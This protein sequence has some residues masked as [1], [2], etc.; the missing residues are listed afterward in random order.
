MTPP[1]AKEKQR[2]RWLRARR[3]RRRSRRSPTTPSSPTATR[4]PWWRPMGRSTGSAYRGSTHPASSGRCSTARP[5]PSAS[6]RS[7]STS[8]APDLRARH[9]HPQHDLAHPDRLG[10]GPRRADHR[11]DLEEGRDHSPHAGARRRG[12]PSPARSSRALHGGVG[13]HGGALRAGLRLRAHAGGVEPAG[14]PHRRRERSG[15]DGQAAQQ[16][17]ARGRRE[18]WRRRATRCRRGSRHTARCRG[19][20]SS[21]RRRT[22]ITPTRA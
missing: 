13:R 15:F 7:G 14:R 22:S 4:A 5:A 10:L 20:R 17:A 9:E 12:R 19:R 16:H 11:P 2:R 3:C 21:P 6:V 8:R 1:K 18:R